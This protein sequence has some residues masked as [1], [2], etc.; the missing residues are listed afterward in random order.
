MTLRSTL[1]FIWNHPLNRRSRVAAIG[2]FAKW[3]MFSRLLNGPL[4]LPFVNGTCLWARPGMAGA[5]GNYYCGLHEFRDMAFVLHVLRPGDLFV[6][7]GANIGSY[8]ILAAGAAGANA[9]ALEPIRSSFE[10]L[11]RNVGKNGLSSRVDLQC[12]GVSD[13]EGVLR[14]TSSFDSTNHVASDSETSDTVDVPVRTLDAILHGRSPAVIKIDVEGHESQV[15]AGA[16]AA[17]QDP[18]LLALVVETANPAVR[19]TMARYGLSRYGYEPF[20]RRLTD[21]EADT[22][23]TIF[24]RDRARVAERLA[25]APRFT[26]INGT[27]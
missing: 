18:A 5:T 8:T 14:F 3:Q 26:L 11:E 7:V 1:A 15:L 16:S 10:S 19:E 6:D 27:I 23:N 24:V 12:L 25:T 20:T 21:P 22:A 2:R 9:V 4:A 13:R 17:L